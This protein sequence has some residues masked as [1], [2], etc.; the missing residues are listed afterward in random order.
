[1]WTAGDN[2]HRYNRLRGRS[3]GHSV[4]RDFPESITHTGFFFGKYSFAPPISPSCGCSDRSD[5]CC[6]VDSEK[7]KEPG[8]LLQPGCNACWGFDRSDRIGYSERNVTRSRMA[9][10]RA[11]AR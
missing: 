11:S 2:L 7:L 8:P 1:M 9:A 4:S 10:D 5:V 3:W 6:L